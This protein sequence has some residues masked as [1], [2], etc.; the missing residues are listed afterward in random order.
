[1]LFLNKKITKFHII[2]LFIIF[3]IGFFIGNKLKELSKSEINDKIL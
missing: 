1:M 2:L 3:I